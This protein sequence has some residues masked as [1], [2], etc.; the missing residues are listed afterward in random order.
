MELF[1][2]LIYLVALVGK[3]HRSYGKQQRLYLFTVTGHGIPPETIDGA[4]EASSD[5]FS[6]PLETKK[7]QSPFAAALNSG[8]E[9]KSQ[10]RP[11][12]GLADQKESMQ[13]T[14]HQGSMDNRWP[15]NGGFKGK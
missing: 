5:F 14:A 11:S 1:R 8:F 15:P 4:F 6:Q 9:F 3:L 13:I 7:E 12:T 10:V 2:L